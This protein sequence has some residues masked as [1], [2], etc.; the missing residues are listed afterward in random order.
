M[1]LVVTTAM[2]LVGL[3]AAAGAQDWRVQTLGGPAGWEIR[4]QGNF[5]VA[6]ETSSVRVRYERKP[7]SFMFGCERGQYFSTQWLPSRPV[8]A[9]S[10]PSVPVVFSINGTP[11]A[12]LGMR[13]NTRHGSL[14]MVE[15]RGASERLLEGLD[16]ARKGVL[17]VSAGGVSDTIPFD[18][19]LNGGTAEYVL[20]ACAN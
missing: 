16:A 20:A 5:L 14:E 18:E 15:A 8:Q 17:G 19:T 4:E 7:M 11:V 6:P 12:T 9:A 10:G 13:L 2:V 1:R 3:S